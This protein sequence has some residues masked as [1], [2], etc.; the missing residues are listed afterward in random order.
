MLIVMV[1]LYL[2]E[3]STASFLPDIRRIQVLSVAPLG[4]W[5]SLIDQNN[6]YRR[7]RRRSSIA[8]PSAN[9]IGDEPS[10]TLR[11]EMASDGWRESD[12]DSN[13]NGRSTSVCSFAEG[14]S[15]IR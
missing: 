7:R 9:A 11:Q 13:W 8:N 1:G 15:G 12:V 14:F 10:L 3:V 2:G 6:R 5:R 4:S